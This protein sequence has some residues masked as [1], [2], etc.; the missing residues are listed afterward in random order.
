MKIME[1]SAV[2]DFY[3][4]VI[5]GTAVK[6]GTKRLRDIVGAYSEAGEVED[7][8]RVMYEVYSFENGDPSRAGT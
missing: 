7:L 1:P 3:S 2:H 8:D 5:T 6:M 4:G